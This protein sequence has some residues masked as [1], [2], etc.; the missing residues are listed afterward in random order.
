MRRRKGVYTEG[1]TGTIEKMK[2]KEHTEETL[3]M[4]QT[5]AQNKQSQV[6]RATMIRGL[7]RSLVI[8]G[9][10]PWAIYHIL[11]NYTNVSPLTALLASGVPPLLDSIIGVIWH[12]RID[13]VAG[14]TLLS[15]A[16]GLVLLRFSGDAK[17]YLL[18]ESFFTA[19]VGL[20]FLISMFFQKSLLYYGGRQFMTGNTPERLAAFDAK[21]AQHPEFRAAFQKRSRVFGFLWGFG[22]LLEAALRTYLVYSLSVEHFLAISP[23]VLYSITFGLF[24]FQ[25][26]LMQRIQRQQAA[27]AQT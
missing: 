5:E 1:S 4:I 10:L 15:I 8:S 16:V 18:R 13:L 24:F 6:S 22:F 17:L 2:W 25:W 9:A 23:F 27:A 12:K 14:I 11:I 7:A 19:A 26:H 3:S 20:A 21:W